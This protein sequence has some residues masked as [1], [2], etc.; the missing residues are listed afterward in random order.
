MKTD[1]EIIDLVY[2]VISKKKIRLPDLAKIFDVAPETISRW[3]KTGIIARSNEKLTTWT[4][5][6]RTKKL[7]F[8]R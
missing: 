3:R 4:I 7:N 8:D 6:L 2:E 5:V 1:R